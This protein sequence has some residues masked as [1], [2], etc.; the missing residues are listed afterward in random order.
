MI[1]LWMIGLS[2][3]FILIAAILWFLYGVDG[4]EIKRE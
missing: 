3:Y 4:N 1:Q 2:A